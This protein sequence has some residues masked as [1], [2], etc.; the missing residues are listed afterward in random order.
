[1]YILS[2]FN[3]YFFPA[4]SFATENNFV[5]VPEGFTL[6]FIKSYDKIS[7]AALHEKFQSGNAYGQASVQFLA[8][9]NIFIGGQKYPSRHAMTELFTTLRCRHLM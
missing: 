2:L 5:Y 4:G 8:A 3:R 9:L 1:M 6:P 7:P